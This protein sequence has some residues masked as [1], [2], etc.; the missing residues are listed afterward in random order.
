MSS[1]ELAAILSKW[2]W[3]SYRYILRFVTER[4]SKTDSKS[5]A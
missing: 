4:A 1:A 5:E 2:L 3:V